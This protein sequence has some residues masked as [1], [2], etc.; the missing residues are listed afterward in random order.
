MAYTMKFSDQWLSLSWKD[1]EVTLLK[2]L[3]L[4]MGDHSIIIPDGESFD[5][6]SIPRFAWSLVGS[7]LSDENLRPG[8]V[9][10]WL[11]RYAIYQ[12][13]KCDDI[14]YELLRMEGKSFFGA[15][16][17]YLAVRCFGWKYYG[18]KVEMC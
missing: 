8:I 2:P 12:R 10:D 17:M 16:V 1:G 4:I 6:A 7:P 5:G 14:F 13:K 11:Y 9:H 15:K 3:E 18:S